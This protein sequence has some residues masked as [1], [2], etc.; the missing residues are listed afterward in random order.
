MSSSHEP[1][2]S[3]VQG[4]LIGHFQDR[5]IDDHG[6]GWS[7]LWDSNESDLW[8][9]GRPS[10]ALIDIVEQT[11]KGDF[12]SSGWERHVSC[13]E[14][15][16]FDLIYD[17]TFLC[18]LHPQMRPQWATRMAQ[19]LTHDG[20]LV[21]LEFPMYKDPTLPG[22]PWGLNGVHWDILVRGGDGWTTIANEAEKDAAGR[23]SGSFKRLLYQKPLRSYENGK[24]TDMLSQC[25]G[26]KKSTT[27]PRGLHNPFP[28]SL[29]CA[30][31]LESFLNAPHFGNPGKELPAKVLE[32]AKG[33]AIC[34]VAKAGF[35][36]SARFGSGLV[37]ARLIDGSWSAPSAISL[38]GVGFGGQFGVELTDFVF[39]LDDHSLRS[40]SRMGN[41]TLGGN[42]SLAF[43]PVGRNAEL[44]TS[45]NRKGM[46]MMYAYSKTKGMFGGVSLEG[47]LLVERRSANKKM[48]QC[49]VTAEQLLGGEIPPPPEAEPLLR[50]L[51]SARFQKKTPT[52]QSQTMAQ[53]VPQDA[54]QGEELP[55]GAQNQPP[56]ELSSANFQSNAPQIPV[57]LHA[58]SSEA[59]PAELPANTNLQTPEQP[60]S[61]SPVSA[62]DPT[63]Q[64]SD[65]SMITDSN[66]TK[67]SHFEHASEASAVTSPP[68]HSERPL[69]DIG[70]PPL[71][72]K[73]DAPNPTES[74]VIEAGHLTQHSKADKPLMMEGLNREK[75]KSSV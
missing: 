70:S 22:P 32:N 47:G 43:G 73:A 13:N 57:E 72:P 68:S 49:K 26:V 59:L 3:I 7:S 9:R 15:A 4:R 5:P 52:T 44:T 25:L 62:A 35:L 28:A 2:P 12:F 8:D 40:F 61:L 29:R 65:G 67:R 18:A 1:P 16:R 54:P 20:L 27:M 19:I 45:T 46:A 6:S 53:G 10:P 24:G 33:L 69:E 56:A 42:I 74:P 31:I 14:N 30:Q 71:E 75:T 39:I 64:A 23:H 41:L 63:V 38:A 58:D 37:I 17:Y 60:P 36:G 21:C 11:P 48:Y 50:I 66:S 34:T 55:S 51:N